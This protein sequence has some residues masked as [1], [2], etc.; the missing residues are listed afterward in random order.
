MA[1]TS[2]DGEA[3]SQVR[4][5][6]PPHRGN[7]LCALGLISLGCAIG[8]LCVFTAVI[9]IPL[10]ITVAMVAEDDLY[11]MHNNGMDPNGI[12]MT[13]RALWLAVVS[14]ILSMGFAL[15]MLVALLSH[16]PPA[17]WPR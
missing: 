10:G 15:F 2:F 9:A 14:V 17:W 5:D 7:L 1:G 13:R 8:A 3:V 16:E 12:D 6:S 11:R 4:R